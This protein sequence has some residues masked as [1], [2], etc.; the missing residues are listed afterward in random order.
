MHE[1]SSSLHTQVHTLLLAWCVRLYRQR[2]ANAGVVGSADDTDH[3]VAA[4]ATQRLHTCVAYS[5]PAV[6]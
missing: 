4:T 1:H 6:Q 3:L 2:F 5:Q